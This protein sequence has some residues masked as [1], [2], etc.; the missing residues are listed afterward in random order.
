MVLFCN[1]EVPVPRMGGPP[2]L[3]IDC[4][5]EELEMLIWNL[6]VGDLESAHTYHHHKMGCNDATRLSS[7]LC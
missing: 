4:S 1:P 2:D 6:L 7:P 5:G 3:S